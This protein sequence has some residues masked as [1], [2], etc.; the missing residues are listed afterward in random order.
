MMT[1]EHIPDRAS[2]EETS[3]EEAAGRW[4]VRMIRCARCG[5]LYAELGFCESLSG[6]QE[7]K[8]TED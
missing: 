2:V 5:E 1:C 7:C 8:M 6:L 3:G 4:K